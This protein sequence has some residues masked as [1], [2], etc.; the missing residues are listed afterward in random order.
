MTT[1]DTV[2]IPPQRVPRALWDRAKE[3]ARREDR[4]AASLVRIA[5]ERYLDEADRREAQK[6]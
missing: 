5:I 3:Q 4:S 2:Q 6:R 1:T